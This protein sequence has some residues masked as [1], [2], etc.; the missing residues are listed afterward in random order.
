MLLHY[1]FIHF[2]VTGW[3]T[4]PKTIG[5]TFYHACPLLWNNLPLPCHLFVQRGPQ[6]QCFLPCA[7][8]ITCSVLLIIIIIITDIDE[9]SMTRTHNC[10]Q[11]CTDTPGSY[12]CSCY[13]GYSEDPNGVECGGRFFCSHCRH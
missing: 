10:H 1:F 9:C 3:S 13:F 6:N 2:L 12:S 11:N 8:S 4:K 7:M 5:V